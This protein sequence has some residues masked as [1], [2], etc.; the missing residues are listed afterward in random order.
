MGGLPGQDLKRRAGRGRTHAR[1]R[2]TSFRGGHSSRLGQSLQLH[3][4][5]NVFELHGSLS[6]RWLVVI[7]DGR[8]RRGNVSPFVCGANRIRRDA[9]TCLSSMSHTRDEEVVAW[10]FTIRLSRG[11]P[12]RWRR[13]SSLL[14][15]WPGRVSCA[16][17]ETRRESMM[18]VLC[19]LCRSR[20][21]SSQTPE[22]P[23]QDSTK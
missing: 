5:N 21:R 1:R 14:P 17:D 11:L 9:G 16:V 19:L 4:T 10:C 15:R 6:R 20:S 2:A 12:D 3:E 22:G 7:V 13:S 18:G 8:G 23:K